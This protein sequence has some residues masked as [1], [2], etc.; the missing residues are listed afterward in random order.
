MKPIKIFLPVVFVSFII[1]NSCDTDP[2]VNL[3]DSE[4][5]IEFSN[6]TLLTESDIEF[7]DSSTYTY[8]LKSHLNT[9]TPIS[10]FKV[11]LNNDSILGGVL[12]S[13]A[14]S[15][16]PPT[17]YF[18]SD[19]FFSGR[20]IITIGHYGNGENVRN[21][22]RIINSLKE[23]NLFRQGLSCQIDSISVIESENQ[24]DV[25]CSIT[26]SNHDNTSYYIPD[27]N[28]MGEEYYTDYTGGL[29]F[30]NT[31]TGLSS[32]IKDS[33][34]SRQRDDINIEDLSILEPKSSVSY[35][36]KSRNYY[37]IPEGEY[38]VRVRFYGIVYTANE[39][40]L[41]QENG[42]IWVGELQAYKDGIIIE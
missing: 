6:G 23:N 36:Y 25:V 1:T 13:C 31:T 41:N 20:D 9:E 4:L 39:F 37:A 18:I 34:S 28:K 8:F 35:T 3:D 17:P 22:S 12:H 24:T 15:S 16:M 21:D 30:S 5:T 33:N 27:L 29:S 32:F 7:Y 38:K 19:C 11:K 2:T 10:D 40:E 42:R 26:I 14:L